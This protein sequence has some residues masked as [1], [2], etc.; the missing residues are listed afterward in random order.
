MPEIG[1]GEILFIENNE[2]KL[3][4]MVNFKNSS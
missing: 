4:F 3:S 1:L 2:T